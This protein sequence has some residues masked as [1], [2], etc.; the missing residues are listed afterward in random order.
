MQDAICCCKLL[1]VLEICLLCR[2]LY[3]WGSM[4]MTPVFQE[5]SP[6]QQKALSSRSIAQQGSLAHLLQT[7]C[8]TPALRA[9]VMM[10]SSGSPE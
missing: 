8:S 2:S 4:Y 6:C 3:C 10:R 7:V 1:I 9:P 5:R